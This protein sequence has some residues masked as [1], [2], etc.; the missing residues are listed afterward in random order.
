MSF[1]VY[2]D[3]SGNF[4]TDT[5][6]RNSSPSL[7]GGLLIPSKKINETYLN[8]LV[9]ASIHSKDDTDKTKHFPLLQQLRD[10]E[11][12]FLIFHNE[13]RLRV[14]N[15]D[16][17]YLN[18]L[19]EGLVQ[20]MR[21][22]RVKY[23]DDEIEINAI[24]ANR[25]AVSYKQYIY[26]EN[27]DGYDIKIEQ[28]QYYA[29]LEEKLIIT[30]G[31]NQIKGIQLKSSFGSATKDKRLMLADVICNIYFS[32][33]SKR[34]FTED[35]RQRIENLY[36]KEYIYSVFENATIG[37]LKRLYIESRYSEMLFQLCS[38]PNL[39]GAVSLRNQL[40]RQIANEQIKERDIYFSYM[41]L[42]ISHYNNHRM[43]TD[44][45]K[46]AENYKKIVLIPLK[47][48]Q[49]QRASEAEQLAFE[50]QIDYWTFDTNFYILT[51]YD[52]IGNPIKC[53][54]YLTLCR[55]S[56]GSINQTWEHLDYYLKYC[57]REL[58]CLIGQ[59]RF[60]EVIEKSNGL[61]KILLDAKNL[62]GLIGAYDNTGTSPR[63]EL[64]GKLY[65]VRLE[66]FMN[67]L[68]ES[69]EL[70]NEALQASDNAIAEF[71]SPDDLRRQYQYRC[72]LM[73]ELLR[74]EDAISCLFMSFG[75]QAEGEE[76]Y[77]KLIGMIYKNPEKPSIF[78]LF[79]YTNVMKL[80]FK[81]NHKDAETMF[82]SLAS[83]QSFADQ[84]QKRTMK[85]HPWNLILWNLSYCYRETGKTSLAD[86]LFRKA[87]EITQVDPENITMYSF[88]ISMTADY[89]AYCITNNLKNRNVSERDF[90]KACENIRRHKLGESIERRFVP[91]TEKINVDQL[92]VI[93]N[94]FLR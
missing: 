41:S 58:N 78:S 45:I 76:S 56:I 82:N 8:E 23:P 32:K 66:A 39:H 36:E 44:G 75:E 24:I 1:D 10:N 87:V 19:S 34:L 50:K 42:Q 72:Q 30:M 90:H 84:I 91:T 86:S 9:P 28:D 21:N 2:L 49:L 81:T 26:G 43:F 59:F 60:E 94:N 57:I 5:T 31:R 89:L 93:S 11:G 47:E 52:H 40:L 27:A 51:M 68:Q 79:H 7:V 61:L 92:K 48:I 65:G 67:L 62:F 38:L 71:S 33:G 6:S 46:F 35:D 13:E 83:F 88:S 77:K 37:N 12:H 53:S 69:P 64:L 17:T 16:M 54:E 20:L 15:G 18:I 22:L 73:V 14:V 74:P 70:A 4:E 55:S 85:G 63:S 3:E 80:L 25:Q 29:R